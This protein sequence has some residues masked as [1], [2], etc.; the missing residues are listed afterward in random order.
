MSKFEIT[1]KK[2]KKIKKRRIKSICKN[3]GTIQ[4]I[5][6][7]LDILGIT[8]KK[9]ASHPT[10]SNLIYENYRQ[11]LNTELSPVDLDLNLN[12]P[13][14]KKKYDNLIKSIKKITK[15]KEIVYNS[16]INTKKND[17]YFTIHQFWNLFLHGFLSVK[18]KVENEMK[19]WLIEF[20]TSLQCNRFDIGNIIERILT[21]LF[22]SIKEITA[23]NEPNECRID[24]TFEKFQNL[25]V[26]YTSSGDITLHNSNSQIN[27]D[28]NFTDTLLLT[29]DKMW[30]LSKDEMKKYHIFVQDYIYNTGDSLKLK[31]NILKDLEDVK[32]PYFTPINISV[33]K[34]E[35]K[36]RKCSEALYNSIKKEKEY[37][38]R[39]KQLEEEKE[40]F[41]INLK[42]RQME[43]TKLKEKNKQLQINIHR[44]PR[45][46]IQTNE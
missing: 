27:S 1:E 18:I 8:Y 25:S 24:I 41:K 16:E 4:T 2:I 32:Y 29:Q 6:K 39:I 23:K 21:N 38:E 40:V 31:R 37:E 11:L 42:F 45:L 26:K 19:Y 5:K 15:I 20:G 14:E 17:N 28:L 33:P 46:K 9:S 35:C 10:L 13:K 30:L 22:N 3:I 43:V 36:N 34:K 7:I 12:I 44:I